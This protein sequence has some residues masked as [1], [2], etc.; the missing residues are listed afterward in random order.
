M[1]LSVNFLQFEIQNEWYGKL[2]RGF[3]N[4]YSTAESGRHLIYLSRG[5]YPQWSCDGGVGGL[6]RHKSNGA[7][8]Y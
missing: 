7:V 5:E 6:R 8:K 1:V 3:K 4:R 2:E